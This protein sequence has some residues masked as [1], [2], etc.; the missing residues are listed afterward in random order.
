MKREVKPRATPVSMTV[1]GRRCW[2]KH[3]KARTSPGSPSPHPPNAAR[4]IGVPLTSNGCITSGY[5]AQKI[6]RGLARP[7][8]VDCCVQALLPI[9]CCLVRTCLSLILSRISNAFPCPV[10]RSD[11]IPPNAARKLRRVPNR[12]SY[13]AYGFSLILH[14]GRLNSRRAKSFTYILSWNGFRKSLIEAR[15]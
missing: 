4:P 14:S 13:K 7:W 1:M 12:T 8:S 9:L 2:T 15:P 6:R 11:R 3:H 5:N 10:P